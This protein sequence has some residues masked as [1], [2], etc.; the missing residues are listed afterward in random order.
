MLFAD[1]VFIGVA[2]TAVGEKAK[3]LVRA[4]E[5][6]VEVRIG[7]GIYVLGPGVKADAG[8]APG[9]DAAAATAAAMASRDSA[10][11][12]AWAFMVCSLAG[13]G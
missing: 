13:S 5:G 9:A 7:S 11:A 10:E 3:P 8:D 2:I 12:R 6:L 1:R 4:V